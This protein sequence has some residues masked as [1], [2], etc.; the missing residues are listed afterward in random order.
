VEEGRSA[1]IQQSVW[2]AAKLVDTVI[3]CLME[4]MEQLAPSG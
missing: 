2:M 1:A 4:A 3:W